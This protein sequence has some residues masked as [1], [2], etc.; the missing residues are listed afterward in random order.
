MIKF[1]NAKYD[2]VVPGPQDYEGGEQPSA[3]TSYDA[4]FVA[5]VNARIQE[6]RDAMED[7][8]LRTGLFT[9]MQI[10]SRGNVYLQEAGLDNTLLANDPERCGV[11]LLNAINLIYLL[12]VVIHPFMPSTTEGILRQLNAPARSLPTTFSIDIL[13]GHVLNKADYLFKKIENLDGAQEKKWQKQFGGDPIVAEKVTPSGP[14]GHPEGGNVPHVG[15]IKLTDKADKKAL[16]EA[17]RAELSRKKK[18]AAVEA[19][20][21]KSPEERELEVKVEAQ[22]KLVASLKKGTTEGDVEAEM[23][24]AKELKNEL[25]ELRKRM[26]ELS[27]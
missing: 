26:K 4:A 17:R 25:T 1:V 20:K 12:S 15:D 9:A 3:S 21:N 7:T 11:I 23:N 5:D 14:N 19:E 22:G 16:H 13:P 2:S 10:S 24:K 27:T 8:K 6:Y 18:E